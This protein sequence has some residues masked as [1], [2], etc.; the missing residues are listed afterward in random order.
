MITVFV[1][2][3]TCI[4]VQAIQEELGF[5]KNYEIFSKP[6][7]FSKISL[8]NIENKSEKVIDNTNR[9]ERLILF[10]LLDNCII[11]KVWDN[12]GTIIKFD[13]DG[14]L[15]KYA[16]CLEVIHGFSFSGEYAL[17]EKDVVFLTY[18]DV[19]NSNEKNVIEETRYRFRA[20]FLRNDEGIIYQDNDFNIKRFN[21][22]DKSISVLYKADKPFI[23]G[24]VSH[25]NKKILCTDGVAIYIFNLE[26]KTLKKIKEY[27][28]SIFT[29]RSGGDPI[30]VYGTFSWRDDDKGFLFTRYGFWHNFL[31]SGIHEM[32]NEPD[33]YYFN[34]ENNQEYFL[35]SGMGGGGI[36]WRKK[37]N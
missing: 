5:I 28:P 13:R 10:K 3:C 32:Y 36:E 31:W 37:A 7:Y 12:E 18:F 9:F 30:I 26:S 27:E 14:K 20:I 21:I 2:V 4:S 22:V 11:A 19:L 16:S 24:E 33:L 29:F 25:D 23:F 17:G 35:F 1:I 6:R 8:L 34:L 15:A